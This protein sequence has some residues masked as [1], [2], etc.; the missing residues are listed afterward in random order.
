MERSYVRKTTRKS[1]SEEAM[2]G[3]VQEVLSDRMGYRR[4]A[5]AFKVPQ[6]TLERHVKKS[7]ANPDLQNTIVVQ[8]LG[9]MKCDFSSDKET[10]LVS[11]LKV[12]EGTHT[13]EDKENCSVFCQCTIF[14]I[15]R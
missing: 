4:A 11:Y 3:A 14:I 10:K 13:E 5:E 7:K 6:T 8:S 12:M 9:P 15:I 2:R 1:W